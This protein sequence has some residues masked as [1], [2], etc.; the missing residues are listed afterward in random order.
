VSAIRVP[1]SSASFLVYLGGLTLFA[2][3]ASLLVA[4]A[5]DYGSGGFV[6]W[7][8]LVF[9]ATEACALFALVNGRRVTAGL[10]ALSAVAAWVVLLGALLDWFG[11]LAH[12]NSPFAGFHVSHLFLELALVFAAAAALAV[13][14]FPLLVFPLGAGTWFFVTDLISGGGD[15]SAVLTVI[16]GLMLLSWAVAVDRGSTRPYAFWLHVVAGLTIGGGLLWLFHEGDWDWILIGL[17]ALLYIWIGDR[18]V[19]SSWVVLGAWALL[20]TTA[21]FAAKWSAEALGA[22]FY[23]F[24]FLL[25]DAF[26]NTSFGRDTHPWAAALSFAGIAVV[27]ILIGLLLARRRRTAIPGAD[28]L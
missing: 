18:L 9:L 17:V 5:D 27:F 8:L 15:W 7:A 13:F 25:V 24:P 11:W 20:Q 12:T 2:S 4:Q 3:L 21:H 14:R 22:F 1:W 16:V 19:R 23:L 28:L 26:G 6:G 10:L